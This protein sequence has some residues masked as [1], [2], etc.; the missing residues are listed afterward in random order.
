MFARSIRR[1]FRYGKRMIRAVDSRLF[2]GFLAARLNGP[3]IRSYTP[4]EQRLAEARV[5]AA[6]RAPIPSDAELKRVDIML[7]KYRSPV[8]EA[9]CAERIIRWTEWPYKLNVFD[10]RPGTKNMAKIFNRLIR[11]STCDYF[12]MIDSDAFVPE[13]E[14]CW[15]T[16]MMRTFEEFPDCAVVVPRV[17]RTS[18]AQHCATAPA[19][20][21]PTRLT[22][23]LAGMCALYKR[24]VFETVG[25]FDEEFLLYGQDTEWGHRLLRS[26]RAAYIRHDV[27]VD[28]LRH[29]SARQ[30]A[31]DQEYD[32]RFEKN[33]ARMLLKQKSASAS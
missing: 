28:H 11:E 13:L 20:I 18:C 2:G 5:L 9:T 25:Y 7:L 8:V 14:P 33:Y 27:L 4:E 24:D 17:T 21:P 32:A 30:A 31:R 12:L 29:Y 6:V 19:D 1:V 22:E 16:R 26:P 23:P 15:L 3:P 10:N